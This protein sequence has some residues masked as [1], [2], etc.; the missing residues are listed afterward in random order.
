MESAA[1]CIWG[2]LLWDRFPDGD[3]LG[4]APANVAWHLG[5]RGDRAILISRV[6]DDDDGRRAIAEL[7]RFV[8]TRAMQIDRERATGEVRVRLDGAEPRYELVPGRAWER[9]AFDDAARDAIASATAV[10]YGTLALR[11]DDG[12]ASWR[13][14]IDALPPTARKVCD[15]NLRPVDVGNAAMHAALDAADV[16]KIGAREVDLLRDRLGWRDPIARLREHGRVVAVTRGADGSTIYTP[17]ETVEIPAVAAR[18]G[19][20]NVGCGDAYVAMMVHGL[21]RGWP[22]ARYGAAA[23]AWGAL[24]AGHRGATPILTDDE[25][26]TVVTGG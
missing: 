7:A 11:T 26:A 21:V 17:D 9:I 19:G 3:R 15:P 23:S 24:V 2:E 14:M 5:Q 18:P 25:R 13:A 20:D 12:L 16:I 10:V 8:D 1:V 22:P 6:G 4:G